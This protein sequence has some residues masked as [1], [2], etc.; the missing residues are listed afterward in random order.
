M[1]AR[2]VLLLEFNEINWMVVD[3]LLEQR[4]ASA[5]PNFV[6]LRREGA[7]AAPVAQEVPPHLDPW[8]T[9]V[10][11]HTGVPREVHGATVLE[12]DGATINARRI[13]DYAVEAGRSVGI[14]G[15]I[16][17]YPPRPVPGFVVPGPFAPGN[18][19]FPA[20]LEPV[21]ALNRRY[22]QVHNKTGEEGGLVDM[23][24]QGLEL[25][26]LGLRPK[27]C[28]Q[29][30]W[31]LA[32]ERT[33]PHSKWKRVSLQPLVNFDFF[34]QLYRRYR[35]EFA[36]WHTNHAAHYMHH[37]WRAWDDSQFLTKS[38]P[39]E[40]ERY[41]EA[42]EYG[43]RVCDELL[44]RFL[45]LIDDDTVMVLASSMGQKPFVTERYKSGKVVVRLKHTEAFLRR[46]GAEGVT[47]IVPTMIPQV[48]VRVPD[49][50]RRERCK[51][52]VTQVERIVGGKVE[53]AINFA[54]AAD[55][56]TLTPRGLTEVPDQVTVRLP[57]PEGH[58]QE[59]PLEEVFAC[60]TPTPKQGMHDPRGLLVFFGRGIK[61]GL[62][63]SDTTNL[64]IAPTLLELMG[65]PVP[66]VMT[67]RVLREAWES[68]AAATAAA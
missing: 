59:V 52:L 8:I 50:E 25:F 56:L 10:S 66:Q 49:P 16:G 14:F 22:T 11:V 37:Y 45:Q 53:P 67:G 15:S 33:K 4:G 64:D 35:P 32:R 12:Q 20:F 24:R 17:A 19:T 3:R 9:W 23:A 47:E 7:W 58:V 30:A 51:M 63:L 43:Y 6:R 13:W 40:K 44:G 26:G 41:G 54:E 55:I 65:V 5:F 46:I 61:P 48:N 29:A 2:K 68:R 39:E 34:S 57:T 42:V 1:Q 27:T 62:H 18:E 36:T 60:D 21:Q 31:Q 38:S 28:A